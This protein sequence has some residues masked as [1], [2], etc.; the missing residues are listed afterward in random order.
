MLQGRDISPSRSRTIAMIYALDY[1]LKGELLLAWK[2]LQAFSNVF[3]CLFIYLWR[4]VG[5]VL[6]IK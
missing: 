5:G 3:I 2:W 1:F 4:G 6:E